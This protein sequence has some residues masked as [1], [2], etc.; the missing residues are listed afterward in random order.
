MRGPLRAKRRTNVAVAKDEQHRRPTAARTFDNNGLNCCSSYA[1][2]AQMTQ[3]PM[4]CFTS[5]CQF[6]SIPIQRSPQNSRISM[7][8]SAHNSIPIVRRQNA[9][10]A[11]T[12]IPAQPTIEGLQS[13]IA[14]NASTEMDASYRS[15]R[16]A[17]VDGFGHVPPPTSLSPSV[18]TFVPKT[19]S[20][21]C[22]P[23]KGDYQSPVL[24]P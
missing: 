1:C 12:A 5:S 3:P 21:H 24:Y 16:L 18:V 4:G 22:I 8:T 17:Q 23:S 9:S 19:H 15:I 20:S 14:G 6:S 13:S 11:M 10:D 7:A 2:T